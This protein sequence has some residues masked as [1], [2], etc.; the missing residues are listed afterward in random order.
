MTAPW[1]GLVA[2]C[3]TAFGGILSR[4]GEGRPHAPGW[5]EPSNAITRAIYAGLGDLDELA[6]ALYQPWT[7]ARELA[8]DNVLIATSAPRAGTAVTSQ[9]SPA[10]AEDSAP[11]PKRK[12]GGTA[13]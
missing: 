2:R 11:E 13:A 1:R 4:S 10:P 3:R 9:A 6:Q 5:V 7:E 8:P 12:R